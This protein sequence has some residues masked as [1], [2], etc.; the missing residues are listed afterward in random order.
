MLERPTL[1]DNPILAALRAAFELPFVALH[2]LPLGADTNT[3]VYRAETGEGTP[4]FV[5]LCLADF[6]E[7]SLSIL[8]P[9]PYSLC[10]NHREY[11]HENTRSAPPRHAQSGRWL[12]ALPSRR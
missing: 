5:K 1:A 3:A 7:P 9:T 10:L 4:Y 11:L 12:S 2:F 6:H 8:L